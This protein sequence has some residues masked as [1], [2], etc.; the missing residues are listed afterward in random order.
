[1][2]RDYQQRAIDQ[3]YDWFRH[4]E[5]NPCLCL[6][7][8]SGKSIIIA[9]LC[10]DAIQSWP[11]TKILLLTHVKELIEQ[12]LK[13]ILNVWQEAPVGVFSASVGIKELGYPITVAGIQ[14]I[15]KKAMQVGHIDLVIVDEAHL[16]SH[17]DEG[18]YRKFLDELKSINPNVRGY[19]TDRYALPPWTWADNG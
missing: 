14:S 9:E 1:M 17:N 15:R 2:L 5:G 18:S 13:Q 10:K 4:N 16:I 19:R 8:G 11:G 3:L 12:D 6:P 7:T